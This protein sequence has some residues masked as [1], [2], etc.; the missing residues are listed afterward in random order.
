MQRMYDMSAQPIIAQKFLEL[1]DPLTY[2][3][4]LRLNF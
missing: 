1:N 4:T 3:L 2:G